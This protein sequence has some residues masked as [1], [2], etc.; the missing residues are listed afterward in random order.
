M[1][2]SEIAKDLGITYKVVW[3]RE[4]RLFEKLRALMVARPWVPGHDAGLP[5]SLGEVEI[6]SQDLFQRLSFKSRIR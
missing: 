5:V 3:G 6:Q 1:E 2:V 4:Q